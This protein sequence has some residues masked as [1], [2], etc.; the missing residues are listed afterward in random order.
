MT[1]SAARA[2][3]FSALEECT[4]EHFAQLIADAFEVPRPFLGPFAF[5]TTEGHP[6]S[7]TA[8]APTEPDA[9]LSDVLQ[10]LGSRLALIACGAR[11]GKTR[12]CDRHVEQGPTLVRIAS[13]GALD[14]LAAA[15]CGSARTGAC[16]GCAGKAEQILAA[17]DRSGL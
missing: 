14:A 17:Y 7:T 6:V 16:T 1:S 9:E 11:E 3:S 15:I 10:E 4:R 5:Q 12:A 13:T 8:L 2:A